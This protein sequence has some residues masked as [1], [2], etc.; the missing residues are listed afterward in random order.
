MEVTGIAT[1][2]YLHECGGFA[3]AVTLPTASVSGTGGIKYKCLHTVAS[4]SQCF[5]WDVAEASACWGSVRL[6]FV[7]GCNVCLERCWDLWTSQVALYLVVSCIVA[8]VLGILPG[9]SSVW[10]W[11]CHVVKQVNKGSA[12]VVVTL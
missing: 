12:F 6:W 7:I 1:Q 11:F 2:A 9:Q 10:E 8:V 5:A 3:A 4:A